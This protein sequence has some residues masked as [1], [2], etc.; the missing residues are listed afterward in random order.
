[1]A[2][3]ACVTL[4]GVSVVLISMSSLKISRASCS[5]GVGCDAMMAVR[6]RTMGVNRGGTLAPF[7]VACPIQLVAQPTSGL[8]GIDVAH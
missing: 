1:M 4:P 3:A 6:K 2:S 7:Y 5:C 8:L